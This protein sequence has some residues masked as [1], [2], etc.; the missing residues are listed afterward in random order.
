MKAENFLPPECWGVADLL[1]E[2][3]LEIAAVALCSH[4]RA[5][6]LF[7]WD[8]AKALRLDRITAFLLSK[9]YGERSRVWVG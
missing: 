7:F 3:E 2:R 6:Y 8:E 5:P 1:D 9:V 4:D